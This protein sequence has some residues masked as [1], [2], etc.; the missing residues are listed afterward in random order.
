MLDWLKENID[1]VVIAAGA[2]AILFW[3]TFKEM[4]SGVLKG[5]GSSPPKDPPA[6]AIDTGCPICN[7]VACNPTE[8]GRSEWVVVVMDL[9]NYAHRERLPDAVRLCHELCQ[10]LIAGQPENSPVAAAARVSGVACVK[11]EIR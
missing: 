7:P 6:S 9:A 1:K 8:K 4:V 3:P 10:E 5:D 11:K 2:I